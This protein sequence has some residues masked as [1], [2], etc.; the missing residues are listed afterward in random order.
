MWRAARKR[1]R[2]D[3]LA[4]IHAGL[5][6]GDTNEIIVPGEQGSVHIRVTR[7]DVDHFL[8]AQRK[9]LKWQA[10]FYQSVVVALA[11]GIGVVILD[12]FHNEIEE[13]VASDQYATIEAERDSIERAL[14][15]YTEFTRDIVAEHHGELSTRLG[16][17]GTNTSTVVRASAATTGTGGLTS[18]TEG[19]GQVLGEHVDTNTAQNLHE[20][21]RVEEFF[22][23]LPGS[24]PLK[25]SHLTSGFGMREH[26]VTGHVVPHRGIDLVSW[27]QPTILAAGPGEVTFAGE[28]GKS[29]NMVTIDHGSAIESLYLHL[30]SIAVEKGQYVAAGEALGV[31]GDTGETDGAHLHYEVRVAGKH[32]DP[33][34]VFE[35]ISHVDE[36]R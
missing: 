4:E 25:G 29:G 33:R 26:P 20:I 27:E 23:R 2:A 15:L 1:A 31:M 14:A 18:R 19:V 32:L 22:D 28:R 35:V 11:C 5:S 17:L 21:A 24:E 7:E 3:W 8:E 6:D 9:R 16:E 30:D 10:R 36:N 13:I 12:V 34:D